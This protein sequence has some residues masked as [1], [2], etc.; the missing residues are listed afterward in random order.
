MSAAEIF[1]SPPT[2]GNSDAVELARHYYGF[3][4]IA[5]PLDRERDQSF[6][7]QSIDGKQFLLKIASSAEDPEIIRFENVALAHIERVAPDLPVPHI[8][9]SVGGSDMMPFDRDGEPIGNGRPLAAIIVGHDVLDAFASR[10]R[11]F[12]TFGGNPVSATVTIPTH[13]Y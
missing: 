10:G 2:L 1:A 11:Y 7:L 9:P 12:N 3:D 8:I 6:R 4:V 13:P 5:T